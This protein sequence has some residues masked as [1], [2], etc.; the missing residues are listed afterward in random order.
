MNSSAFVRLDAAVV[1]LIEY[2]RAPQYWKP[3]ASPCATLTW[4]LKIPTCYV[5]HNGLPPGLVC[6]KTEVYIEMRAVAG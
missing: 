6:T 4:S 2:Y 3:D 1:L 5:T